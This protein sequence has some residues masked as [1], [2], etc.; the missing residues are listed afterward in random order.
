MS[1]PQKVVD[2]V[3]VVTS[4]IGAIIERHKPPYLFVVAKEK[5]EANSHTTQQDMDKPKP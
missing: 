4:F 1:S 2:V 3:D 5:E